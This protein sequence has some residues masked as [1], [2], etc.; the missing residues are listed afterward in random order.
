[1]VQTYNGPSLPKELEPFNPVTVIGAGVIGVSWTALFLARGLEVRVNDVRPDIKEV[2]HAGIETIIPTLRQLGLPTENLTGKLIIE[3]NLE[4]ALQGANVVQEAGPERLDFKQN[5]YAQ[6]EQFVGKDALLLSASSG[7]KASDIGEKLKNPE[8]MLIGHPFNPPHLV[9]LVEVVPGKHTSS[10]S[11]KRAVSFYQ[12]LGKKPLVLN[13]EIVGFVANRLQAAI[14]RECVHLV[15]EEVVTM[16]D[17]DDIVTSSIGLRWAA[18][19]PFLSFHLG[20]GEGGF[21]D[22]IKHLGPPMEALWK[23]LG[24]PHFDEPTIRKLS[25]QANSSYGSIPIEQLE[26]DRDRKQLAILNGLGKA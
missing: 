24:D 1:M 12:I 4:K 10:E 9:P 18:G 19:G 20:G 14:F 22:F 15:L 8:R 6:I 17:L 11:V 25:E 16:K 21:P 26:A 23:V 2:V 3:P 7:I 5:L 13:K